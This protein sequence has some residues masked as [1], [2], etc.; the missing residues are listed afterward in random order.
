MTAILSSSR[1]YGV[2]RMYAFAR[3]EK[4][5]AYTRFT[6]STSSA[7]RSSSRGA[8]FGSITVW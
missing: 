2:A 8:L 5:D 1:R 3:L 4:V 6:A 7:R